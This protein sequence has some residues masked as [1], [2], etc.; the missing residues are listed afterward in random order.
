MNAPQKAVHLFVLPGYADWE[1]AHAVAELR[2]HGQY[3]VEVVGETLDPVESMGGVRVQP[4]RR[5]DDVDPSQVAVFIL[6]GGDAWERDGTTDIVAPTL[7]RLD[8]AGVP[9]AAICAGTLA[10]VRAGILRGR[11]HTSNGFK[12]LNEHCPGYDA[13][14]M[15]QDRAAVRD[16]HLITANGLADVEFARELMEELDVLSPEDREV[17]SSMFRSAQLPADS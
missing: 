1:P 4:T 14:D 13:R 6:P 2:R 16:R 5:L 7:T 15:Y 9:I 3:R 10:V 11:A 17:W 12:Y 8:R